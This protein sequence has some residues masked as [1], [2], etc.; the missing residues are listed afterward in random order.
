MEAAEAELR[1]RSSVARER[2]RQQTREPI[3]NFQ[4]FSSYQVHMDCMKFA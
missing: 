1:P 3:F 4:H 2:V